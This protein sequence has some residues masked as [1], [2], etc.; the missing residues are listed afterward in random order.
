MDLQ[1]NDVLADELEEPEESLSVSFSVFPSCSVFPS[2]FS[3]L[4]TSWSASCAGR[5]RLKYH[6]F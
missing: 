2:N 4:A 5:G 1:S 6:G 3:L